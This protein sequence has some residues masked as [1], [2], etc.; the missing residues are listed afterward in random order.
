MNIK[1]SSVLVD[2]QGKALTFYTES[3]SSSTFCHSPRCSALQP[4]EGHCQLDVKQT[5]C[6]SDEAMT[7]LPLQTHVTSRQTPIYVRHQIVPRS[8]W[9]PCRA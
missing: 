8:P 7:H 1:L 6:A 4:W 9:N 5:G 2:D 3:R